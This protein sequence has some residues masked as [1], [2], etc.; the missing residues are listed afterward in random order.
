MHG[1]TY[2]LQ[3]ICNPKINTSGTLRSFMDMLRVVENVSCGMYTF[4]AEPDQTAL[5]RLH[6]RP[7]T[8]VTGLGCQA[9]QGRAGSS[10]SGAS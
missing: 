9:V 6:V 2:S 7:H 10:S 4:P 5:C 3:F 1:F 8:E